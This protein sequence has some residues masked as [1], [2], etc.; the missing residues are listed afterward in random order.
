PRKSP[1]NGTKNSGQGYTVRYFGV[2]CSASLATSALPASVVYVNA[3]LQRSANAQATVRTIDDTDFLLQ[4][5][6]PVLA[7]SRH[8]EACPAMSA[9]GGEADIAH[10]S[11]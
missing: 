8:T 11:A 2:S 5:M 9:F 7:Q 1:S 3:E 6:S 10:V 4:C